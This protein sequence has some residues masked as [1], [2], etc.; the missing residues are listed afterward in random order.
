MVTLK[1][2]ITADSMLHVGS[3]KKDL[4]DTKASQVMKIQNIE[5]DYPFIPGTTM[6]GII[7]ANIER[8]LR[9]SNS[10]YAC[11][12][13][14]RNSCGRKINKNDRDF[15]KADYPTLKKKLVLRKTE[16]D[17]G[18][19][20]TCWMFGSTVF[21]AATR[22]SDFVSQK[23]VVLQTKTSIAISRKYGAVM[24]NMLTQVEFVP[25]GT[26]FEGF[27]TVVNEKLSLGYLAY[28]LKLLNNGI[29][30]IGAH[31]TKGFGSV[32]VEVLSTVN[33]KFTDTMTTDGAEIKT[34]KIG[35]EKTEDYLNK[36]IK[37][38]E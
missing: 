12:P 21:R 29:I 31:S 8:V 23:P 7:R 24:N 32:K 2:K 38:M 36:L 19:C 33:T 34:T 15:T 1:L 17:Q 16:K 26:E 20:L 3:G 14:D 11:D 37:Q 18:I 35:A 6:K 4:A 30:T 28:T 25:K 9:S 13:L 10:Y 5:G 22:I 27:I